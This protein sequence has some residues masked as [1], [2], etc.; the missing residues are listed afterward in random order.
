MAHSVRHLCRRCLALRGR[1][2]PAP[3]PTHPQVAAIL[4]RL[5]AEGA[6]LDEHLGLL[7]SV[8]EQDGAHE[9]VKTHVYDCLA[10]L[11]PELESQQVGG[12][13]CFGGSAATCRRQHAA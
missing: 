4:R 2:C 8:T 10:E 7:W 11:V 1:S 13:P 3:P 5:A 6:L 9:N 12:S